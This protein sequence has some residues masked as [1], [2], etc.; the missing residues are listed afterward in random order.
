MFKLF[1]NKKVANLQQ[2]IKG[3]IGIVAWIDPDKEPTKHL[4]VDLSQLKGK[5][6][7]WGGSF[8]LLMDKQK[9]SDTFSSDFF[10][11]IPSQCLYAYDIDL[12]VISSLEKSQQQNLSSHYPVIAVV[13]NKGN[14]YFLSHGYKIGVGE[15][16]LK[17]LSRMK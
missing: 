5:F 15:Q 1:D 3:K 2:V 13:D 8:V 11:N 16:L 12:G 17:T 10:K 7:K 6:E 14:Y 9:V 4:M